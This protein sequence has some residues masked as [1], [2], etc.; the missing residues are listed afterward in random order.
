[1]NSEQSERVSRYPAFRVFGTILTLLAGSI[2]LF[3]AVGFSIFIGFAIAV[4]V[5]FLG[6]PE[7]V[8][9]IVIGAVASATLLGGFLVDTSSLGF[10]GTSRQTLTTPNQAVPK[11]LYH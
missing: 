4:W 3:L 8:A 11:P 6:G 9:E 5:I 7:L 1:M 2:W 10:L